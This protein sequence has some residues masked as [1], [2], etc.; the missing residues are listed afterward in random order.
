MAGGTGNDIYAVDNASDQVIEAAGEGVDTVYARVSWTMAAGQ[1]IEGLR[2]DGAALTSG[3]ILTGNELNNSLLGGSGNDTLIG[4]A[5]NDHLEGGSGADTFVFDSALSLSNVDT[6]SDFNGS[7]DTMQL[8]HAV[9]SGLALGQLTA[10]EFATGAAT[11][12][13]PQ[14]V[15]DQTSGALSYDVDGATPGGATKFETLAGGPLDH[16]L[17]LRCRLDCSVDRAR[18]TV[19]RILEAF[20]RRPRGQP[21]GFGVRWR[22]GVVA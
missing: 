2:A 21:L 22:R 17:Q 13:G 8:D 20:L 12:S 9:F 11:G 10:S 6:V 15:Y 19:A 4:G 14:I 18:R 1:E 7:A 5:G 16:G 3:V